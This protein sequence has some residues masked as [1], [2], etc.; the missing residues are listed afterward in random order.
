[1]VKAK[2]SGRLRKLSHTSLGVTVPQDIAEEHNLKE[3]D[4]LNVEVEKIGE[5]KESEVKNEE[6]PPVV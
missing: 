5:D 3:K 4:F 6:T 1:M 2:F